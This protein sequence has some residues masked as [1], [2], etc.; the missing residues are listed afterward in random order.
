MTHIYVMANIKVIA[1]PVRFEVIREMLMKIPAFWNKA[2]C[3]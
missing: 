2:A 1:D 3:S